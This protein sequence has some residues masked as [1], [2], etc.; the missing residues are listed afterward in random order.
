MNVESNLGELE[1]IV[2]ALD[3]KHDALSAG[4]QATL[5]RQKDGKIPPW[6]QAFFEDVACKGLSGCLAKYGHA[7][8]RAVDRVR[9][10]S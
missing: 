2:E 8:S 1:Q 5:V 10:K 3:Q 9:G 4:V 6:A 7:V